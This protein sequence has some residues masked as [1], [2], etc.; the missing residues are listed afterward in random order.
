MKAAPTF[1]ALLLASLAALHAADSLE[2][3]RA[4]GVGGAVVK[5]DVCVY[6]STP[7]GVMAAVQAARMGRSVVLV[8]PD[9]HLGGMSGSGLGFAD[10]G[11]TAV[12]GGL[13]REFHHR[14]WQ[15]YE[16]PKAW[17]WQPR[18]TF[19]NQ[20][21]GTRAKNDETKTMWVFEPHV[22]EQVFESL[23]KEYRIPVYREEW[24][25]RANGVHKNGATL[26]QIIML[27]GKQFIAKMFIDASYEGDLMAAAGVDYHVG[28]EAQSVYG[29]KWNGVQTG[30]LHHR[31]HFGVLQQPVSPYGV[32]DDPTSGVI[33]GVSAGPP[34]EFG[35]G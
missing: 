11:N 7:S 30:V 5:A 26:S 23:I 1:T 12:I 27:S 6:G 34:G 15:H 29:E 32:P 16:D 28:R 35:A 4:P 10:T 33:W 18:E 21:Q 17:N 9:Q 24:L 22:A 8:T 31:H 2:P 25:D 3:H 19:G 20:G 13:A 14:I